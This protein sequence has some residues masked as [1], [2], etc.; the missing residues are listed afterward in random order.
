MEREFCESVAGEAREICLLTKDLLKG[1]LCSTVFGL[2]PLS[3][4]RKYFPL[5]VQ[6]DLYLKVSGENV[7]GLWMS[8]P[9]VS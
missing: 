2:F 6:L 8:F 3:C 5:E 1:K 9:S 4:L 7:F